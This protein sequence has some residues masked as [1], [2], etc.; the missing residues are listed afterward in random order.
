MCVPVAVRVNSLDVQDASRCSPAAGETRW[1]AGDGL[2]LLDGRDP[3]GLFG[4]ARSFGF[5]I[6]AS[7]GESC[8]ARRQQCGQ[9]ADVTTSLPA[10][11]LGLPPAGVKSSS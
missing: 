8:C 9:P 3:I 4:R 7:G 1:T 6:A 2:P 10:G 5:V 11:S